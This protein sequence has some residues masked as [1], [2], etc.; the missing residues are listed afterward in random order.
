MELNLYVDN[1]ISVGATEEEVVSYY[2]EAR[3]IMSSAKMNLCSWSSS[4]VKL[5]TIAT[6]VGVNDDSQSVNMLG[7][8]WNTTADKLSLAVK[9]T[10]LT[11]DHLVTKREVLQDLLKVFDPLGFAAPVVIRAKILMQ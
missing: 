10:I 2:K 3:S 4:S 6:K 7:L 9:S 5:N 11:H 1:V 8:R